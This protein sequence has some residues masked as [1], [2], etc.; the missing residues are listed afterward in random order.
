MI[1]KGKADN[2]APQCKQEERVSEYRDS[3]GEILLRGYVNQGEKSISPLI[4]VEEKGF[5]G[6]RQ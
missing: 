2:K 1:R 4:D 5:C 3:V 6:A